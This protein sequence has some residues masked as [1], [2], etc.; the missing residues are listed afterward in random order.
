MLENFSDLIIYEDNHLLVVSKPAG[1]LSQEDSSGDQDILS[2]AK[3]FIKKRDQ[4]PFN[5]YLGLVHR[6]DRNTG[7]V[8]C[9]AKTSKAAKRLNEQIRNHN[10]QKH[11]LTMTEKI[12]KNDTLPRNMNDWLKLE[13]FLN[14]NHDLNINKVDCKNKSKT[15][16]KA[17]LYTRVLANS[18]AGNKEIILRE[19]KL[20]TGRSHQIRVQLASRGEKILGDYKYGASHD[21]N[22]PAY[23]LGLWAYKLTLEHPTKKEKVTFISLPDPVG[24]WA[25]FAEYFTK[26]KDL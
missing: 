5:V 8:M 3:E 25:E 14:K 18:K 23:F 11:Y 10:W 17:E 9:F 6:L 2:L 12:N 22:L 20:I 24:P 26:L 19:N 1:I 7:G 15:S 4:K 21:F 16:K 13:D